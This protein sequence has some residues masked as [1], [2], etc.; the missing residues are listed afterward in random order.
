MAA[1]LRCN[2]S[3]GQTV[4]AVLVQD[5][6]GLFWNGSTFEAFAA[7]NWTT[8]A[9][10]MTEQSTTGLFLGDMPAIMGAQ[11]SVYVV[12]YHRQGASPA[13]ANK[14]IR[15]MQLWVERGNWQ[16]RNGMSL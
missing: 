9:V 13:V 1:E 3:T 12:F 6:G 7:G 10:T 14:K 16:E 4:Y 15:S 2:W 5:P 8:Y 11:E